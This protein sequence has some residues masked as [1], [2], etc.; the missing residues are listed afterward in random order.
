MLRRNN[1]DMQKYKTTA[2]NRKKTTKIKAKK[3]VHVLVHLFMTF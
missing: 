3:V 1:E 2:I